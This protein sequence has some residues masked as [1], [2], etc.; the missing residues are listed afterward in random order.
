[1]WGGH[2]SQKRLWGAVTLNDI[3]PQK[4]DPS[5]EPPQ[6]CVGVVDTVFRTFRGGICGDNGSVQIEVRPCVY[7]PDRKVP[8]VV[9]P[10][11]GAE[12]PFVICF[13]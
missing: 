13:L 3:C 7:G 10:F 6:N 8:P 12:P 9:S 5:T 4:N 2:L 1:M 11:G